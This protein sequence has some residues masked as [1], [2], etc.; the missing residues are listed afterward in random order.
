MS[1]WAEAHD[2]PHITNAGKKIAWLPALGVQFGKHADAF[3]EEGSIR[4]PVAY[5]R[6][7]EV[8]NVNPDDH[9]EDVGSVIH[10]FQRGVVGG[11][12]RPVPVFSFV[13]ERRPDDLESPATGEVQLSG[14]GLTSYFLDRV[15]LLPYD[16]PAN[17]SRQP[18]WNFGETSDGGIV[19]NGSFENHG[20]P[21]GGF[22]LGTDDNWYGTVDNDPLTRPATLTVGTG[23]DARTGDYYGLVLPNAAGSS[24]ARRSISGLTPGRPYVITGWLKDPSSSRRFRAGVNNAS[25]A[26]HINAYEEEGYWWAELGNATQGNGNSNG[27]YQQFVIQFLAA[28]S[29]T[30]L[31]ILSEDASDDSFIIDDWSCAGFGLGVGP[32]EA[33]SLSGSVHN[34]FERST[35]FAQDGE[36][37]LAIQG[38]ARKYTDPFGAQSWGTLGA[39]QRVG[40]VPGRR[41]TGSAWFYHESGSTEQ[42]WVIWKR[43]VQSGPLGQSS[44]GAFPIGTWIHSAVVNVPSG[45]WTKVE[46]SAI[47]DVSQMFIEIVWKAADIS[48]PDTGGIA[49]PIFYI[50]NV[51]VWEGEGATN[52]GSMWLRFL[53]KT[54]ALD[55]LVPSFDATND[56][57]GDPWD[58][59]RS[60]SMREGQSLGQ[61]AESLQN[62]FGYVHR[63]RYD[64]ED[65]IYYFDIYNPGYVAFDHSTTDT[66]MLVAG[67]N[68][69]GGEVVTRSPG[70]TVIRGVLDSGAWS[71]TEDAG[72]KAAWGRADQRL[73]L[74]EI[75]EM[76]D[77]IEAIGVSLNRTKDEMV[78]FQAEGTN[79]GQVVP[80][81]HYDIFHKV[82]VNL[83]AKSGIPVG[84][85]IVTSM[86]CTWK[87]GQ[88]PQVQSFVNSDA[89]ASSGMAAL[90]EA[91]RRLLR[92]PDRP[93][94][95]AG[96]RNPLILGERGGMSHIL[97]V[98]DSEPLEVQNKADHIVPSSNSSAALQNIF[99]SLPGGSWSIWMAGVFELDADVTVPDGAW[100]RGLGHTDHAACL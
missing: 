3:R 73:D 30:E 21:N 45:V 56:S 72:L 9:S 13:P 97:I 27:S 38:V 84:D 34:L 8:F 82:G 87:P 54:D 46:L 7:G 67:M 96:S 63:I 57:N 92:K 49:S 11:D 26:F 18:D 2:L 89:F 62:L 41:Y 85:R 17:P 83:G 43:A 68:I 14:R 23:A 6:L 48:V 93:A 5:P 50:D 4:L 42:F 65:N 31:L 16:S 19:E 24:G 80:F 79:T 66:G 94:G 76:D 59:Q 77:A 100:I 98:S 88:R 25:S 40:V 74:G 51:K 22:E 86:V 71:E 32:W 60:L 61:I 53:A 12:G 15:N 70:A 91:V 52:I 58:K 39:T 20:F 33:F 81:V 35:N 1:I 90:A 75:S 95:I 78:T 29:T 37:S 36:A 44:L 47:P 55:W 28:S 99:D 10:L 64:R 69:H